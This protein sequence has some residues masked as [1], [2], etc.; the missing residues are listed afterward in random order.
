MTFNP[1]TAYITTSDSINIKDFHD[2]KEDY[3][4]RPPYQRKSVWSMKKKQSL[5]DSLFRRYY[6]PRIVIREVRLD[7]E[8]AVKEIIDGQQRIITV[9]EFFMNQIKLPKSLNDISPELVGKTYDEL[10]IE[11]KKFVGKELSFTADIVK[12]IENPKD[13]THQK[14]ATEIFWRLQQGESLNFMEIAHARLN[15]LSRNFIVKYADDITFDFEQYIPI[16]TNK[17][18]HPFFKIID[19]DND[20]MQHLLLL[21]RFLMIEEVNDYT[22]LKDVYVSEFIDKYKVDNGIGNE[23]FE[24]KDFAKRTLANLDLFHEIFNKDPAIDDENGV[25]ELGREYLIISFYILIRHLKKYYVIDNKLKKL[26]RN[27]LISEFYQRW[28]EEKETDNEILVFTNHRQMDV[29][30]LRE[31]DQILRQLFFVYALKTKKQLLLKDTKRTFNEAKK[32]KIYRRDNGL[33]QICLKEGKSERE[34]KVSWK[35]YEADHI[36]PFSKGGQ[37]EI[38]NAQVLC[39]YHNSRKSNH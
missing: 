25:K 29:A 10:S 1:K 6:I 24:Q 19:R 9:Q 5:L 16:D 11:F 13:P 32:I 8:R 2:Y 22:E 37:T 33:C 3:I 17:N 15:S 26:I 21:T 7:D 23:S 31:R 28:N 20:R 39:K 4:T 36:F 18:K 12:N 14:T 35:N 38:D 30:S 34:A 27:F